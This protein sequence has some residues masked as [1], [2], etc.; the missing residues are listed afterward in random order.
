MP[1]VFG[2]RRSYCPRRCPPSHGKAG[3]KLGFRLRLVERSPTRSAMRPPRVPHEAL[4]RLLID[5]VPSA[6]ID[7]ARET[8]A[9]AIADLAS[10]HLRPCHLNTRQRA[11]RHW[12]SRR[13]ARWYSMT[14]AIAFG[15]GPPVKK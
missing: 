4:G 14:R 8:R 2:E 7:C 6:V 12:E 13:K 1:T 5:A 11:A 9:E 15:S 10:H 3:L